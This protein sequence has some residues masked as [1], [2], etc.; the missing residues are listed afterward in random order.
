MEP[1]EWRKRVGKSVEDRRRSLFPSRRAAATGSGISEVW[2]RQIETGQRQL[3]KGIVVAPAPSQSAKEK[4]CRRLRWTADSID[5]LLNGEPPIE[6]A[7]EVAS[8]LSELDLGDRVSRLEARADA[9]DQK[10]DEILRRLPGG[11]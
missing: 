7:V 4:M 11:E 1:S 3:A 8:D 5:R 2:W 10:L 6:V 9:V